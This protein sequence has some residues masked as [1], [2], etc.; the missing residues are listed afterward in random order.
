M[1]LKPTRSKDGKPRATVRVE[2]RVDFDAVVALI[3]LGLA[4]TYDRPERLTRTWIDNQ[5]R[6][7]LRFRG[8]EGADYW[9]DDV[10]DEEADELEEWV[11]DEVGRLYSE[12]R[13]S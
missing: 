3:C 2:H 1:S 6:R 11:I 10:P 4:G 7:E 5:V 13:K 9:R 12:L 8:L